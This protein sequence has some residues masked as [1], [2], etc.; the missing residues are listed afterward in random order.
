VAGNLRN[1]VTTAVAHALDQYAT[2]LALVIRAN[3]QGDITA[4]LTRP[5]VVAS[6]SASLA[7]ARANALAALEVAYGLHGAELGSDL[8]TALQQDIERAYEQAPARLAQA[9][10]QAWTAVPMRAYAPGISPLGTNPQVQVAAQRAHAARTAVATVAGDIAL[11]N[12]LSVDVA[13][14]GGR[15]DAILAEAAQREAEGATPLAKRWVA[16]MDGRDPRSCLWCRALH[17]TEVPIAQQ[18]PHPGPLEGHN[19]PRLYRGVL[20]G[21]PLHPNC[22]CHLAVTDLEPGAGPR[23][24]SPQPGPPAGLMVS[25]A[26]IAALPEDRYHALAHF[27]R[28]AIHE[29]GQVVRRLVGISWGPEGRV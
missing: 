5:D 23:V 18:F 28:S 6:L 24:V 1:S 29:L 11:R 3:P 27:L 13:A 4:I 17:G 14:S 15:T 26:D 16:S 22:R 20:H 9:V 2:N 8:H 19:P 10:A 25:S 21:P 12:G 7:A